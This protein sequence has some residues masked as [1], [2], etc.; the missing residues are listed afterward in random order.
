MVWAAAVIAAGGCARTAT[1]A[2]G[3]P[4]GEGKQALT[5]RIEALR[6]RLA[7]DRSDVGVHLALARALAMAGRPGGA[8]RH[9]EEVLRR[10][11]LAAADRAALGR[12]YRDRAAARLA[13]DDGDAWRDA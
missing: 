1:T 6:F 9:F 12:L 4:A 10:R 3:P 5:R 13:L 11:R 2:D 7:G 8:I